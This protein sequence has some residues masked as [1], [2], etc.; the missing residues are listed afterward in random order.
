MIK[1]K[2]GL[3]FKDLQD[4]IYNV[5]SCFEKL[6]DIINTTLK[7]TQLDFQRRV[8]KHPKFK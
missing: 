6:C 5:F 3:T 4:L 2:E 1:P 7:S 8:K